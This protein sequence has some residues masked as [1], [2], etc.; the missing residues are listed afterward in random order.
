MGQV[1][2]LDSALCPC[3][4]WVPF[5][6]GHVARGEEE[7]ELLSGSGTWPPKIRW[8]GYRFQ[9]SSEGKHRPAGAG[10]PFLLLG[11]HSGVDAPRS[12]GD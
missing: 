11:P 6:V 10:L 5:W 7:C 1:S 4:S 2:L 12:G 3:S 9:A 8:R